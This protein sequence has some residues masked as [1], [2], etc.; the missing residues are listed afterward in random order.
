MKHLYITRA[1][2][3][4]LLLLSLTVGRV[5]AQYRTVTVD[6]QISPN[7]GINDEYGN[8]TD[9]VNRYFSGNPS[10][11]PNLNW[12]VTWDAANLYVAITDAN[13]YEDA[14]MYFDT[15]PEAFVNNGFV[16]GGTNATGTLVAKNI[17]NTGGR[18][19]FRADAVVI[20]SKNK[21]QYST[22]NGA[23]GWNSEVSFAANQSYTENT[24]NVT[25]GIREI[26]IPWSVLGGRPAT[27]NWLGYI[28][29][30]SG[31]YG[32]IPRGNSSGSFSTNGS[33]NHYFTISDTGNGQVN[34]EATLSYSGVHNGPFSRD[35]YTNVEGS[36]PFFGSILAYDF[37]VNTPEVQI[38]RASNTNNT[39]YNWDI[40]GSL[41][42]GSGSTINGG[43]TA[44]SIKVK[45]DFVIAST[46]TFSQQ[47]AILTVS[48]NMQ[49]NTAATYNNQEGGAITFDGTTAQEIRIP[50]LTT[51]SLLLT[52]NGI[53]TL[54]NNLT[55]TN[56]VTLQD[57]ARLVTGQNTLILS[58]ESARL[59]EVL[60]NSGTNGGGY[61]IGRVESRG[62]NGSNTLSSSR[63]YTFNNIGLILHP[64][65]SAAAGTAFPGDVTVQRITGSTESNPSNNAVSVSRQYRIVTNPANQTNLNV[66]LTFGYRDAQG[67]EISNVPESRLRVFRSVDFNTP[68]YQPLG[69]TVNPQANTVTIGFVNSN[70]PSGNT[71]TNGL[72]RLDGYY[73]LG[74][75]NNPLPVELNA[76]AAKLEN[77]AVRL[78]WSTASE[79][80]NKGFEVQ[81]STETGK[82]TT[83]GFVAGHGSSTQANAYSYLDRTAP[84]GNTAYRLRQLDNDGTESF[85]PIITLVV[86]AG[87]ELVS[88]LALSPVPTAD[89]LTI[90][91]LST[92]KHVAEVYDMLGKRVLTHSFA[93][94]EATVSVAALPQG[95][96][97]MV[98]QG[99]AGQAP[100]KSKF[101]KQ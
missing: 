56:S 16:N 45:R 82:W 101:V 75:S 17:N 6:G 49:V 72:N 26:A 36:V 51:P 12:Y 84:A 11:N 92:G 85:S 61:V 67:S 48:G 27:F 46:G 71:V 64:A 42:I 10:N 100:Q 37:T 99:E 81:R 13:I 55:I 76:F 69:G 94:S 15:D 28:A 59:N 34:S 21:Q 88:Q 44:R 18:L 25:K 47:R 96:Y 8:H 63:D 35:S 14:I 38:T 50:N 39:D 24:P 22:A 19:P 3:S 97:V 89:H 62:I 98:V 95:M 33:F 68:P 78:N 52:G 43:S 7:S 5:Q 30:P 54:A 2:L 20:F 83:L 23:N 93:N 86:P 32:Q 31:G 41:K 40:A 77:T 65:A 53:K 60:D 70:D 58:G 87:N 9:G 57:G 4:A 90:S 80:N 1:I 73:T 29:Y 79:K 74:D 91:G 66:A